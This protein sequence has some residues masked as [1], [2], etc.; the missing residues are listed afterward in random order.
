MHLDVDSMP[1]FLL[2]EE[3]FGCLAHKLNEEDI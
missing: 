2:V 3:N 1:G